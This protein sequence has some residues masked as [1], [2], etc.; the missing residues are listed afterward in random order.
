MLMNLPNALLL[1][2]RGLPTFLG[3]AKDFFGFS[4]ILFERN[5][6]FV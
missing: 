4:A 5:L 3:M 1:G 6:I 2:V